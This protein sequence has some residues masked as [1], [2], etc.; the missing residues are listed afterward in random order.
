M[1]LQ[2][3]ATG[4]SPATGIP[5][6]DG[7]TTTGIDSTCSP[8]FG[9][10]VQQAACSL[11]RLVLLDAATAL[12]DHR[13]A[14]RWW[15]QAHRLQGERGRRR[16]LPVFVAG[17]HAALR[18]FQCFEHSV[19]FFAIGP[20]RFSLLQAHF[21][22]AFT[23]AIIG[24]AKMRRRRYPHDAIQWD[25]LVVDGAKNRH[26][27]P[28]YLAIYS[29]SE[30]FAA[31]LRSSHPGSGR[32]AGRGALQARLFSFIC[33]SVAGQLAGSLGRRGNGIHDCRTHTT[34]FQ[35]GQAR[36]GGAGRAGNTILEHP[37][38]ISSL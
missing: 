27:V 15:R 8:L 38:M 4:N 26:G 1:K 33:L 21:I 34:A 6:R 9:M 29:F 24:T 23:N 35:H 7:T 25:I 13:E 18:S 12:T 3:S 37:R 11:V 31:S 5:L 2:F 30:G 32:Y 36:N 20:D 10:Q 19:A 16:L 28:S 17:S 22:I 14:D